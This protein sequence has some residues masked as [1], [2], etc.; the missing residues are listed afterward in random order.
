MRGPAAPSPSTFP[1]AR[2]ARRTP[3]RDRGRR[4]AGLRERGSGVRDQSR[5]LPAPNPETGEP[6]NLNPN[7]PDIRILIHG[8]LHA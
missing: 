7:T 2:I 1:C 4:I 6:E 5:I 3:R 8:R